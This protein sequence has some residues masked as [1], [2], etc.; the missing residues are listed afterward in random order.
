MLVLSRKKNER[1]H[2]SGGISVTVVEIR[3]YKVLLGFEA[4]DEIAILREEIV[5]QRIVE[6]ANGA[7]GAR[8]PIAQDADPERLR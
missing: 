4:P 3:G 1:I 7:I 8:V 2:L 6:V 5:C